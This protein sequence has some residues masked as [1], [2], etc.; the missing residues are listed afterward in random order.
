MVHHPGQFLSDGADLGYQSPHCLRSDEALGQSSSTD[1]RSPDQ[2]QEPLVSRDLPVQVSQHFELVL[3]E[4]PRLKEVLEVGEPFLH[5]EAHRPGGHAVGEENVS[6]DVP[7][8]QPLPLLLAG[9]E[10][11]DQDGHA[12][13]PGEESVLPPPPRDDQR[14]VEAEDEG[15]RD[16]GE[17]V[18]AVG[19]EALEQLS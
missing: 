3:S 16:G 10:G 4:Q 14:D 1:I 9:D 17:F 19:D 8:H 18:V 11:D 13:R 12:V 7:P 5:S 2:G 6:D 15:E